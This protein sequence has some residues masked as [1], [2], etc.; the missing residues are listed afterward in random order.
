VTRRLA[1]AVLVVLGSLA[2]ALP[3]RAFCG[4]YVAGA[5]AKLFADATEVVLM[6]DGTRT[7]LA[8]QNHYAGPAEDFAMVIP[9]PVVLQKDQ[10]R[11]LAPEI[12]D[13]IDKLTAPRLVEYWEQD[14]CP[15]PYAV[16]EETTDMRKSAGALKLPGASGGKGTEHVRVEAQY[17]VGEYEIVILGSDDSAALDAWLRQ[18]GYKIPEGAEP[19]LRPYIAAGSKFFVAKVDTKKV[20]FDR[21]K[22]ALLSPLRFHYDAEKFS[23]PVRLGLLSSSGTQDLVVMIVAHHQRYEL[24]N[25][26]NVTIPTN[27][28]VADSTRE[29]F[30]SFYASLFDATLAK[31]PKAVVTEYAWETQSCDPCPVPPLEPGDLA[32][33]GSDVLLPAKTDGANDARQQFWGGKGA[34]FASS[35]W[36]VTRLHAR[37]SKEALGDDLVFR[38]AEAI[39]GGREEYNKAQTQA[40]ASATQNQFQA[41]Y[42]MRHPWTGPIAC[43]EPAFG[44]WGDPPN[45]ARPPT[46]PATNLAFVKRGQP[47]GSWV[48]GAVDGLGV[49]GSARRADH[50]RPPLFIVRPGP[51]SSILVGVLLGGAIVALLVR[52]SRQG[53]AS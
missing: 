53:E 49:T 28:E 11:T 52:R 14:P 37:Y 12:F 3:A 17:A 10:V 41:R 33:L 23:L 16:P 42:V 15:I 44:S 26:P 51:A 50:Q 38:E 4:F 47:L 19:Y 39:V 7:I 13:R 8:M 2:L 31:N 24:A 6:R 18:N 25:Y 43:E 21:D 20:K 5:D 34:R 1:C 36:V 29:S 45:G 48:V 32:T 46:D 22:R 35:D 9:V 30:G 40:T 27:I